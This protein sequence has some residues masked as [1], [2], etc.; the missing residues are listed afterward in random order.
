[1]KRLGLD[2]RCRA[3]RSPTAKLTLASYCG[4]SPDSF[5]GEHSEETICAHGDADPTRTL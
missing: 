3:E 4:G 5:E 1:M 2:L